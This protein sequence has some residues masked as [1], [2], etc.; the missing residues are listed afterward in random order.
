MTYVKDL[1]TPI[2][3]LM[4]LRE[5]TTFLINLSM[6]VQG[7]STAMCRYL[8]VAHATFY[9]AMI[10]IFKIHE[11]LCAPNSMGHESEG[12]TAG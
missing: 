10:F 2:D 11:T 8:E 12:R 7:A 9:Y 6:Y 5:A 3:H 4:L 1:S